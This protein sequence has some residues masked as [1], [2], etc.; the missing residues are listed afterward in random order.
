MKT[1]LNKIT[2]PKILFKE[3]TNIINE[4]FSTLNN[5]DKVS[6]KRFKIFIILNKKIMDKIIINPF[7][8]LKEL[9][10]N[11]CIPKINYNFLKN[12]FIIKKEIESKMAIQ[13]ILSKNKSKYFVYI[14]EKEKLI[15]IIDENKKFSVK[16]GIFENLNFLRKK[17]E[18]NNDYFFLKNSSKIFQ[19]DENNILIKDCLINDSIYIQKIPKLKKYFSEISIK[20]IQEFSYIFSLN[21]TV[22]K[23]TF[24]KNLCLYEI[25]EKLNLQNNIFFLNKNDQKIDLEKEDEIQIDSI[26]KETE[27]PIIKKIFLIEIIQ[28]KP[29]STANYLYEKNSLKIYKYPSQN[30]E[31]I[32]II[33]CKNIIVIG[34]TGS[35]KT[36]L[37][38][39]FINFLMNIKLTDDF[40]YVLIDEGQNQN[41][42][43]SQTSNINSYYILP[44][45]KDFPPIKIIDTP[46]FGDTRENLKKKITL[47]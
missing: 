15:N 24:Q 8:S 39:S 1:I 22:T 33:K 34:E 14:K 27:N 12:D 19:K 43:E 40:R 2:N 21:K 30:F 47:I 32:D 20:T 18:I 4:S 11:I 23:H 25:R 36:T 31:I 37:I 28:N 6:N 38:N 13:E 5:N 29:I 35:G 26:A 16:I 46:G 7:Q 45:N 41:Q 10:K 44:E 42:K 17:I 3:K 9:R